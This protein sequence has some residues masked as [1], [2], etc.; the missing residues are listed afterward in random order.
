MPACILECAFISNDEDLKKLMDDEFL[1]EIAIKI[2]DATIK[3]L[4]MSIK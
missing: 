4:N 1:K 3:V 2:G